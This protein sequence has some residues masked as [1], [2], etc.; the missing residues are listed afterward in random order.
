M[1]SKK[2]GFRH[3]VKDEPKR[4]E[5]KK[6]KKARHA[7]RSIGS[8]RTLHPASRLEGEMEPA[9]RLKDPAK[10]ARRDQDEEQKT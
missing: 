1:G 2:N 10:K 5:V 8:S 4:V 3:K 9:G 6:A 7:F